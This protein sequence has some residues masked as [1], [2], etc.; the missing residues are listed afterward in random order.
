MEEVALYIS[1]D[2]E[3]RQALKIPK[4]KCTAYSLHPLKWLRFLG[5]TVYGQEGDL[6]L[7]QMAAN[8]FLITH[9]P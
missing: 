7:S 1:I 4:D 6:S 2:G 9:P 8:R 5:Y 3:A